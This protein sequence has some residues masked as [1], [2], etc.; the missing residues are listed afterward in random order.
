MAMRDAREGRLPWPMLRSMPGEAALALHLLSHDPDVRPDCWQVLQALEGIW[1][2]GGGGMRGSPRPGDLDLD[3][4]IPLDRP[5]VRVDATALAFLSAKDGN[6]RI[7]LSGNPARDSPVVDLSSGSGSTSRSRS[8]TC[9]IVE[10]PSSSLVSTASMPLSLVKSL[11]LLPA[12]SSSTP[13][14][15]ALT[16]GLSVP[17]QELGCYRG[18]LR[19]VDELLAI[20]SERDAEIKILSRRI[21][22]LAGGLVKEST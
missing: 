2:N 14:A 16:G 19:S 9:P 6:R 1:G 3:L 15:A 8:R 5:A 18:E 4:D 11:S 21:A 7:S 10:Y 13:S 20:L 17:P 22:E 12:P